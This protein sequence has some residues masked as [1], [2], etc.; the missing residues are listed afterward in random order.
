MHDLGIPELNLAGVQ[1]AELRLSSNFPALYDVGREN[2]SDLSARNL[3]NTEYLSSGYAV[4]DI[5]PLGQP[6]DTRVPDL[7][8]GFQT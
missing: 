3:D 2:I 8:H 5:S 6:R 4:S 7:T 1:I